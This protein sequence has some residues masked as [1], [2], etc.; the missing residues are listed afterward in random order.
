MLRGYLYALYYILA[1]RRTAKDKITDACLKSI[2]WLIKAGIKVS[3]KL[4]DSVPADQLESIEKILVLNKAI[5]PME[6]RGT[7]VRAI[8]MF[9]RD[10]VLRSST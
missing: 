9:R 1:K 5:I 3:D 7:L 2:Q 10:F 6:H 4:S 8:P